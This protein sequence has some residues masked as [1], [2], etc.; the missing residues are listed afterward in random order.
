M[1]SRTIPPGAPPITTFTVTI[2]KLGIYGYVCT[3]HPWMTGT[4]IVK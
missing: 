2:E 1:A 3:V 4:V